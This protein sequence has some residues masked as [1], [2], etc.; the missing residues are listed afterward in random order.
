[1]VHVLTTDVR[2]DNDDII[3]RGNI[4]AAVKPQGSISDASGV[5]SKRLKTHGRVA[6][7]VCGVA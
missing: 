5:V 2:A 1:M 7:S 4:K 3:G 6:A